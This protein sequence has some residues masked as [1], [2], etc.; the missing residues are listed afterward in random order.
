MNK[1]K[2]IIIGSIIAAI[3]FA[4]LSVTYFLHDNKMAKIVSVK[5]FMITQKVPYRYCYNKQYTIQ[6]KPGD[7]D[8]IIGGVAGGAAGG[9][10]GYAIA[11]SPVAVGVG[12]V[13]GTLLGQQVE[14]HVNKPTNETKTSRNCVIKYK[15]EKVQNG[16]IVSY[17]YKDQFGERILMGMPAENNIPISSL[18]MAPTPE[19]AKAQINNNVDSDSESE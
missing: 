5:P 8:N 14:K 19:Q 16:Y 13:G 12:A 2:F 3:I 10:I 4:T 7:E 11:P 15:K 9:L 1:T 18:E 17:T 6:K